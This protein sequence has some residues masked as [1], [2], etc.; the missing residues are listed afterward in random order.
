MKITTTYNFPPWSINS[1]NSDRFEV[2][3]RRCSWR[4]LR[5]TVEVVLGWR[6]F[7]PLEYCFVGMLVFWGILKSGWFKNPL[8]PGNI[9]VIYIYKQLTISPM[10]HALR[11][12]SGCFVSLMRQGGRQGESGKVSNWRVDARWMC[13]PDF[14]FECP[15]K[16]I[17]FPKNPD[18]SR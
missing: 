11:D 1:P 15:L 7:L 3:K 12:Q 9:R 10:S 2:K 6:T 14:F 16:R 17:E 4:N 18:P 8:K 13:P 5:V